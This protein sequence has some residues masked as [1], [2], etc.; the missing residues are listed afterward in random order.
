MTKFALNNKD[1][2]S[3]KG[4]IP[5]SKKWF[6]IVKF[7]DDEYILL[8]HLGDNVGEIATFTYNEMKTIWMMLSSEK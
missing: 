8:E 2:D 1:I 7:S 5:K 6:E 3:I 4:A